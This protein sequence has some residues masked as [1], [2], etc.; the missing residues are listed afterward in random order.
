LRFNLLE[1]LKE[2]I[3]D[4]HIETLETGVRRHLQ[5][6]IVKGKAFVCILILASW[7]LSP[8]AFYYELSAMSRRE[9]A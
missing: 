4:F 1:I 8:Q 3:L 5:Y 9:S 6:D 2:I 7:L